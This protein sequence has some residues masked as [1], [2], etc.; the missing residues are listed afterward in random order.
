MP[1]GAAIKRKKEK[2][3]KERKWGVGEGGPGLPLNLLKG[4]I[5]SVNFP[6]PP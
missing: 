1:G 3:M 2:K 4:P 6:L 5:G